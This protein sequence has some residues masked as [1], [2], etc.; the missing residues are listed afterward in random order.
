MLREDPK[1]TLLNRVIKR[2]VVATKA[3]RAGLIGVNPSQRKLIEMDFLSRTVSSVS[4]ITMLR[5]VGI[6]DL[7]VYGQHIRSGGREHPVRDD[8]YLPELPSKTVSRDRCEVDILFRRRSFR[9]LPS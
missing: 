4:T 6:G 3:L 7:G 2:A 1:G 8:N 5:Y 9:D